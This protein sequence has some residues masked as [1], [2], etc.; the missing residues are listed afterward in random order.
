MQDQA[1]GPNFIPRISRTFGSYNKVQWI[2]SSKQ[3]RL[4]ANVVD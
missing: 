4:T 3:D 1:L 2:A